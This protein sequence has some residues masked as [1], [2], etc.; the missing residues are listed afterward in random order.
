[1]PK[2]VKNDKGGYAMPN[3]NE[4]A[5]TTFILFVGCAIFAVLIIGVLISFLYD[6]SRELKILNMEIKRTDGKERRYWLRK[7]RRLLISLIPF[8][9]YR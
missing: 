8:V 7:R 2:D 3:N 4:S 9:P 1:M 6:F 5:F